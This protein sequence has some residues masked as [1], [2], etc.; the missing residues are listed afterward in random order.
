M[1]GWL[2]PRPGYLLEIHREYNIIHILGRKKKVSNQS[3]KL[4]SYNDSWHFQ[5][6]RC[7]LCFQPSLLAPQA[8]TQSGDVRPLHS[9]NVQLPSACDLE[10]STEERRHQIR[11]LRT[12]GVSIHWPLDKRP[13]DLLRARRSMKAFLFYV[14]VWDKVDHWPPGKPSIHPFTVPALSTRVTGVC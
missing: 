6:P 3:S 8:S 2:Q 1:G 9:L 5:A 7:L 14:T 10:H 12:D 13:T 4:N 11:S